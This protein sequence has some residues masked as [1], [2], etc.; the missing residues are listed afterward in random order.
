MTPPNPLADWERVGDQFYRKSRIYDAVF[1]EDVELENY[2]AVG[3]PYG[4]AIALYRDDRRLQRYRDA[5]TS[6]SSIDIYS[7]SGHRICRIN[8]DHGSIRGLGWSDDEK[9]LAITEDGTVRC[10]Y[11]LSGDFTP[12]S[13]GSAAEEYGVVVCRF[14]STGFVALLSNNQ[15]VAVSH[16]D[17]PRPKLLAQSPE[18]GISSWSLIPPNY[19]LSRSV[20]VLLAIDK[21][22]YVVDEADSEDR[23]LQN[24]PFKQVSVSPNG[25]FVALFTGDGKL[26]VVSSDFQNKFGEYDSQAKTPPG[27][28]TWC[29]NGA[30]V[31]AWEDEVHVVGPNGAAARYFYEGQVHII[32]DIDGIRILTNDVCEFLHKVPDATEEVFRLGS[33]APASVLLDSVEQLEKKSSA[34]DENIQRIRTN[35]VEAVDTCVR[36]AGYE[37]NTHWQKQL[38]KAASFGKSILEL[39]NSDEFVDM[40]EKLRVLNAVRDYKIGLPISY[41][42]YIRLTPEKLIERLINRREYLLAIRVS[43]YLHLPADKIFV[44]WAIQKVRSSTE[45][46][47]TICQIVVQRLQG[48]QGISFESIARSAH[49]EGRSH[50]ATQL[51]NYEPRAG[52]QVPLLLSMEEDSVA[53]DKAT[54]SGDT[55]L[56]LFV[57]LQLKRKLPLATFFRTLNNRPVASALVEASAKYQD[58]ELLKD[59]Y[60]Q[61]DRAIDGSNIHLRDA[62]K[63]TD[64]HNKTDKLRVAGRLLSDSKDSAIQAQL[65]TLNDAAHLL[66]VQD[67]LDRDLADSNDLFMGLS[68]NETIYRLIRSGYG[69]RAIKIQNDFKVP[70]KT[71]WWLRLRGLVAKRDWGE[72]EELS[73]GKKSPIGWEPFYNE[74]L[75]AGNTKL[76]SIFIPKCASL[77]VSERIDMWM[78]CGMVTRAGEEALKAKDLK[79]LENLRARISGNAVLEIDRMINQLKPKR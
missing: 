69:K 41:E 46:D 6:K 71:Y 57:L 61:D 47:D 56:I 77:T 49:E 64:L 30:V 33:S 74:I 75:G 19:T 78:K 14:W 70:E 67:G 2:I 13:L 3:A 59:L 23:M 26:W 9:L 50:L 29:G 68:V 27:S 15:L 8:W 53:L 7:C 37:F 1:D 48:K 45:D 25:L 72:L 22:I 44:H 4:G 24:G 43:E 31:L 17:E 63:Q 66:K 10:Y 36:A 11:G 55:D 52:K 40:C 79:A 58:E 34:A 76:A 39:Y 54:E 65:K 62:L 18:G 20:E 5:Q 16:Y 21:T 38:L 35:L 60:Y 42:Q 32:P 12:F 51:L 73:K 28:V